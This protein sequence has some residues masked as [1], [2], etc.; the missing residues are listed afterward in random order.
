MTVHQE[1][2]NNSQTTIQLSKKRLEVRIDRETERSISRIEEEVYK[3]TVLELEMM[4]SILFHFLFHFYF[5]FILSY[6]LR[7]KVRITMMSY[8]TI[9]NYYMI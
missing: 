9:T 4:N 2:Y 1:F 3:R 6:I 8:I 7:S 5:I